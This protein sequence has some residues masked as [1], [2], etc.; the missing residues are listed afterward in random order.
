MTIRELAKSIR[1]KVLRPHFMETRQTFLEARRNRG[2]M[3]DRSAII[4]WVMMDEKTR[5][6]FQIVLVGSV[7]WQVNLLTE[8]CKHVESRFWDRSKTV[9]LYS[10]GYHVEL[11]E[12][13]DMCVDLCRSR[14]TTTSLAGIV[15]LAKSIA[16]FFPGTELGEVSSR[17]HLEDKV[18]LERVTLKTFMVVLVHK[19]LWAVNL[20]DGV[21][22]IAGHEFLAPMTMIQLACD[23]TTKL[24]RLASLCREQVAEASMFDPAKSDP[25]V[26]I[27]SLAAE[28]NLVP[29][30]ERDLAEIV[31]QFEHDL[32]H[33]ASLCRKII[34]VNSTGATYMM[35]YI[36][37][38][39][40][41]VDLA[42]GRLHVAEP[43][44]WDP[45]LVTE[46][47]DPTQPSLKTALWVRC[48]Q[49]YPD[50]CDLRPR[51]WQECT[52]SSKTWVAKAA[53]WLRISDTISDQASYDNFMRQVPQG[54]GHATK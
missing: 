9:R 21:C 13:K 51:T 30:P 47:T 36:S 31:A 4:D 23:D 14:I 40:W 7:V 18:F 54:R 2:S 26:G 27:T 50:T 6:C 10:P 12:L 22:E 46:L 28:L 15:E 45:N 49:E 19:Q 33:R 3:P 38:E 5:V 39:T 44:F 53:A 41:A 29:V 8:E 24:K 20:S 35:I 43:L 16:W 25:Q 37:G 1:F 17:T 11:K 42:T 34:Q 52:G 32:G 48:T